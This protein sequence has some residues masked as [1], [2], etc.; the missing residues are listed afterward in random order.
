MSIRRDVDLRGVE[1][2]ILKVKYHILG[3]CSTKLPL[4]FTIL[5]ANALLPHI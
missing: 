4:I 5:R 1:Q 2:A 3:K